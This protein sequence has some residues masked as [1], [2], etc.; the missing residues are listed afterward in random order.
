MVAAM[1]YAACVNFVP[2]YRIPADALG[3]STL[4][5]Q[6]NQTPAAD[7]EAKHMDPSSGKIMDGAGVVQV[8]KQ[9]IRRASKDH[10]VV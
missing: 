1:S 9:E 6:N 10:D 5:M 2:A 7:L 3:D 4:G 8:E